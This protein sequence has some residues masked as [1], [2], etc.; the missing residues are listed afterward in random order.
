MRISISI[1]ELKIRSNLW[2]PSVIYCAKTSFELSDLISL[3]SSIPS[4]KTLVAKIN[5]RSVHPGPV[6]RVGCR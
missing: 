3:F 5:C 1:S 2:S 6:F 4:Q